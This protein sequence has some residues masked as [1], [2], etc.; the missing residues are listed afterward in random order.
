M[1][2]IR[3][4]TPSAQREWNDLILAS[5]D[6]KLPAQEINT[7]PAAARLDLIRTAQGKE[8]RDLLLEAH[9][10]AELLAQLPYQDFYLLLRQL[11][12][13]DVA[14]LLPLATSEQIV[15]CLD[16]DGWQGGDILQPAAVRRWLTLLLDCGEEQVLKIAREIDFELLVL[17]LKTQ[18][19]I[20]RSPGEIDDEEIRHEAMRQ[21]GGYEIS[22]LHPQDAEPVSDLL[23]I[24][25]RLDPDLFRLTLEALRWEA[26]IELEEEVYQRHCGRL[27]DLGFPDPYT[28]KTVYT[29]IDRQIFNADGRKRRATIDYGDEPLPAL[30]MLEI[31]RPAGLLATVLSAGID[32][33][34]AGELVMLTNKVLSADRVDLADQDE[35]R[36]TAEDLYALLNL[37][38]EALCGEEPATAGR[39]F[40]AYHPEEIF[41]LGFTL[42]LDLQQRARAL[43]ASPAAD[44]LDEPY[45]AILDALLQPKPLFSI[46]VERPGRSG[47]RSFATQRDLTA[48][49]RKLDEIAA[50]LRYFTELAPFPLPTAESWPQ[51]DISPTRLADLTLSTL[52]LTA[53]ANRLL[54]RDFA[55]RPL[56]RD[57]LQRLHPLLCRE[58]EIEESLRQD[59]RHSLDS[60]LA[61]LGPFCDWALD[62]LEQEFCAAEPAELDLRYLE[63]LITTR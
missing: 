19:E 3:R 38:L 56:T 16:L 55:P 14:E 8:K 47:E 4:P 40:H 52:L 25:L 37:G 5:A 61:G 6:R 31:A 9:D 11:G 58:G 30:S 29:R 12:H 39:H 20:L 43:S 59:L 48:T 26:S 50:Q 10:A 28:A 23:D 7:L 44:F 51:E 22:F 53:L 2:R 1:I 42:T 57:D 45:A 27:L 46:G 24:L 49:A 18:I 21:H 60:A 13:D 35:L 54:D 15:T 41:R 32:E 63:G 17:V 36:N 34:V 62:R 33:T